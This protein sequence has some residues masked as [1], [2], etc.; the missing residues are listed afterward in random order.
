MRKITSILALF[1]LA[2][3]AC[4]PEPEPIQ[5]TPENPDFEI[6]INGT[7]RGSVTF[8]VEPKDM[9]AAYLCTV[10]SKAEYE[11]FTREDF[12][13]ET[14]FQELREEA[15]NVGKTLEEYMPEVVDRGAI[16]EAKFSGLAAH[17]DYY[18]VV[19]GVDET[20]GYKQ[21]TPITKSAFT[22]TD[23]TGLVCDFKVSTSVENNSV[24]MSVIP[25]DKEILWYLCTMPKAQYDYYVTAEDGYKMTESYFYEYYFQQEINTLL[26][27]GYTEQ[28]VVDALI[29][30]GDLQLEA[31]GLQEHTDYYILVAGLILDEEGIVICTDV[32]RS[33]YR[34]EGAAQSAM[35][36]EIEVWDI[37]QMEASFRIT[38][39]N[40][41]DKYC[42]LVAP[43]DGVST[44]EE[45]MHRLVEQWG[46]WMDIMSNDRGVVEHAGTNAFKLPAADTDYYIIAFGYDGGITTEAS[47]ATF[48]TLPGG[49]LEEV[50][51]SISTTNISPYGFTM[52]ITS[53]DPTIYYVPGACLAGEY[54]EQTFI[55]YEEEV[56]D[57]YYT[58]SKDF[59]PSIT[60]CEV[61]DQYYYNGNCSVQVSGLQ[62]DTEIMAYIFALDVHTGK[63]TKAYTFDNVAR[64][65]TLGVA[66]PTVELVGYFSGDEEAGAIFGDAAATKGKAITVVKYNGLDNVRTLFTTMVE[67][68]CSNTSLYT[69]SEL[70]R[71]AEGYWKTCKTS[72]PYTFYL[73]DWNVEQTALV[74]ATDNS[75][76]AGNIARLYTM[77]TAE[78]KGDIEYLK[79]LVSTL[80]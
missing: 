33:Q 21:S 55:G 13:V 72:S 4:H 63:V 27:Q 45:Q 64:T 37:G 66:N 29:H 31:K 23:V 35:T 54:D 12:F 40:D 80:E 62:P 38:P 18:I 57:Y 14:I 46:G 28:Q 51:F 11:E 56:F 42:A 17:T 8:S 59:N 58:G 9:D 16:T 41:K 77:P 65:D 7:T 26:Q 71:I 15:S 6:T 22:T 47:M 73:V 30:S 74:Y 76:K 61:L 52:N 2:L 39:S 5:P 43:W 10:Y 1:V 25:S 34:T 49:S 19:F 79:S 67:G 69:D 70:W 20:D 24:V 75:G 36:F 60:I 78:N 3:V 32:Q 48:R 68:D 50:E 44:A 53:S